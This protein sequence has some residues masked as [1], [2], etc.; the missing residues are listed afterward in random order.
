M[1]RVILIRNLETVHQS[2]TVCSAYENP[3]NHWTWCRRLWL[4]Y[5]VRQ[6]DFL[7]PSPVLKCCQRGYGSSSAP[8]TKLRVF[9]Q[10]HC[11]CEWCWLRQSQARGGPHTKLQLSAPARK[12]M[13]VALLPVTHSRRLLSIHKHGRNRD[14]VSIPFLFVC[15]PITQHC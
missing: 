12:G 15:S 10:G 11:D 9:W 6:K 4:R 1:S 13:A 5:P 7:N 8:R 2:H 14:T 3:Q